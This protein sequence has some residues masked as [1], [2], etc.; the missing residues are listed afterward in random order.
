[1][2]PLFPTSTHSS[3]DQLVCPFCKAQPNVCPSL[4]LASD[5]YDRSGKAIGFLES[6]LCGS[7]TA[8]VPAVGQFQEP[9]VTISE[10]FRMVPLSCSPHCQELTQNPVTHPVYRVLNTFSSAGEK[11]TFVTYHPEVSVLRLLGLQ[12]TVYGLN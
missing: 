7:G 12:L 11:S 9:S 10:D 6:A 4:S 8:Y 2:I 5:F 1:M 3:A